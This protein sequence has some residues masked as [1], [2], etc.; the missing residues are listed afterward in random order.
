VNERLN[1]VRLVEPEGTFLLW[2]DF[3]ETGLSRKEL[4]ND[5][6]NSA[7]IGLSDGFIF[8]EEGSGFQRMNIGCARSEIE[9]A[10]L[11]IE[12]IDGLKS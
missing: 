11:S 4:M 9:K 12:K 10:L 3:R 6:V 8:G 7:K 5:L 1:N 2:L